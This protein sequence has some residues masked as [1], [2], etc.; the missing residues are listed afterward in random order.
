MA[1]LR[2]AVGH[3]LLI[4]VTDPPGYAFRHA[5]L[6]E[7]TYDQLLPGE[8]QQLHDV[9][10]DVLEECVRES[11]N[12]GSGAAAE[13]AVHHHKAG[14]RRAALGWDLRGCASIL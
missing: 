9:W 2:E 4:L 5:L 8:R 11:G 10:A 12:A 14:H 3:H 13:I 6:A 7:A 1:G